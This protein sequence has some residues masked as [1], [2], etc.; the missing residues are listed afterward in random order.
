MHHFRRHKAIS[1]IPSRLW[2]VIY[3]DA[4][5]KRIQFILLLL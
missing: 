1:P 3:T 4:T 5:H 2:H